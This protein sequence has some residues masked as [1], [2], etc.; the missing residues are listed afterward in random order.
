MAG[1]LRV[2]T[3][4][5]YAETG[6]ESLVV[7][8]AGAYAETGGQSLSA[9]QIGA[10]AELAVNQVVATCVGA[11]AELAP[12]AEDCKPSA[13]Y[14][15][16]GV[17]I[18]NYCNELDL[19]NVGRELEATNFGSTGQEADGGLAEHTIRLGG[20]WNQTID[21]LL[22]PDALRGTKR[23]GVAT[24]DDCSVISTYTW[25][26]A[27]LTNWQVFTQARGKVGWR[28]VLRHDG[29]ATRA[30]VEV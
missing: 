6:E 2:T 5:A 30:V 9:T 26:Q 19:Q 14:S 25:S 28:A 15:F 4:G 23:T 21:A 16:G 3:A 17:D 1:D 13:G 22:G 29:A 10:Y 18:S 8:Q 24:F 27:Y 20:D 7:S 11:Y 12:F